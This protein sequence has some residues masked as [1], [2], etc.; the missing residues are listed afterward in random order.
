MDRSK[1]LGIA[2]P[3][4]KREN[5]LRTLLNTIPKEVE[6]AISDNGNFTS[7]V[8]K[9]EFPDRKFYGTETVVNM[10][11]NWNNAISNLNTEWI[12]LA[13]DDDIFYENAFDSFFKNLANSPDAEIIIFGHN[14]IDENGKVLGDWKVPCLIKKE[15][16]YG[17]NLFKYGVDAR[18]ISVF[19]K[20]E[21]YEKVGRLDESYKITS[22]DSDFIQLALIYGRSLFVPEIVSGYR[23]W[24]K[25]LT[26]TLNTT[27]EWMNEIDF[28]QSKIDKELRKHGFSISEIT[29][30]V[31]EVKARNLL[32]AL[33][34]IH[35]QKKG[36]RMSLRY[37]G[38]YKFP[39]HATLKTQL[40]ILQCLLKTALN[41]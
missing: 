25:S 39:V 13:S 2:I 1:K 15:A 29:T 9:N 30:N 41:V 23:I 8:F 31:S 7:D 12:C 10:F 21:L 34:T 40:K 4:Y 6:V 3:T 22:A 28:W 32:S 18:P 17:Y 20:R 27:K 11:Q 33:T 38:E 5:Y 14:Y 37:L 35:K 26:S 36:I 19:F 16:P 24:S